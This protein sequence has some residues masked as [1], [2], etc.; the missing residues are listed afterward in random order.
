MGSINNSNSLTLANKVAIVS[1]A[2]RGIG[3]SIALELANRG[4]KVALTYTSESSAKSTDELVAEINN[5]GN[6]AQALSIRANL[7][8]LDAPAKIVSETVAAFG[9]S[10]D[11]LVN[12]AAVDK[13]KKLE[14]LTPED[15]DEVFH[16]NVRG[17]LL[18]TQAVVPRLRAPGRILN[19]SSTGARVAVPNCTVYMASKGALES[20]T[21]GLAQELGP[22]GHTVNAVAP[23]PVETD[24]MNRA[25]ASTIEHLKATTPIG[26]LGRPDD[27]AGIVGFLAEESSRWVTGQTI[28]AGGGLHMI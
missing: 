27:I 26:R 22:L 28:A 21:R 16:L 20:L 11:I 15:F 8:E 14:E 18:L 9:E 3:A 2:S 12:N 25:P 19:I 10:I 5:L 24:M 1:G 17:V 6:G 4:A 23:G 7:R 13:V